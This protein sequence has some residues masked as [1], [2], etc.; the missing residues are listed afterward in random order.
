MQTEDSEV[1]G[2]I[3][4][5]LV[6]DAFEAIRARARY[7]QNWQELYKW[8]I[9]A[10]LVG[11]LGG[12]GAVLFSYTLDNFIIWFDALADVL[13]DARLIAIIPAIGGLLVGII[14]YFWV[15]EQF[16]SPCATDAMIDVIHVDKGLSRWRTPFATILVASITLA[17]GGSAG[18]ECPTALIGTGFGA[19]VARMVQRLKLDKVLHFTL[20]KEDVRTLAICG[21]AAGLGAVF[22]A[23]IGSALFAT[24]VLYIYGM[25]YDRILPAM[26]S[27]L[28]SFLIF[29]VFYGF[30]SLFQAPFVW[31]MNFFDLALVLIIGVLASLVGLLYL[32]VFYAT[33]RRFQA[34]KIPTWAKPA[35]GGL[36]MGI[37]VLFIPRVWGMGYET[38]QDVIDYKLSLGLLAVL[39]LGK[40]LA[41]S[42]SIGSGGAGGVIAPSLFIG[43]AL[44][45]AVGDVA[46][47]MF[48]SATAHPTLYVIAGMGALYASIGKV[49]LSTAI[50]LCETTRNFT[51]IVPLIIATT[52]GFLASGSHTI[53]ESQHADATREQADILSRVPVEQ[54]M[55]ADPI[56]ART[57]MSVIGLLRL[58]GTTR[59]HGFPVVDA[60]DKLAGV[61]SWKDAQNVPYQEREDRIVATVMTTPPITMRPY[62]SAR[63]ALDLIEDNHI[64]RVVVVDALSP[65]TVVGIVTKED[66]IQAYATR[67][68]AERSA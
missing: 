63:R 52:A 30:E 20:T 12:F 27:S 65:D 54:V 31:E 34:W 47:R 66:L 19:I 5:D 53:Y 2:E 45:G 11:T 50:I 17:S 61:I 56:V 62:E 42:F 23:P 26:I 15:P 46:M 59:H 10:G 14:R 29:S 57:D 51:M 18:R 8:S 49:P 44:G 24:S 68:H 33:F 7:L 60:H 16:L 41:S 37:M 48:P 9:L 67:I 38:I 4:T 64:G 40:M 32:K 43:A 21:A 1:G 3:R 25:E 13:P 22:R 6:K 58:V 55:V 35:A 28:T 36:L 39:I